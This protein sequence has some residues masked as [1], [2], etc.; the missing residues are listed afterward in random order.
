VGVELEVMQFERDAG[1]QVRLA[2]QWRLLDGKDNQ[3]LKSRI[4]DLVS[5]VVHTVPDF[6]H[7]VSIMS[8]LLGELSHIIGKEILHLVAEGPAP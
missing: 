5:P 4:T 6:E 8:A 3:T 2:V 1:G 7:T